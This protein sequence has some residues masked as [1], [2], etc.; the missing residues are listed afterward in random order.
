MFPAI[1]TDNIL[2]KDG[3]ASEKSNVSV[4][5][6][7]M[8][9]SYYVAIWLG[10]GL[11]LI[12]VLLWNQQ[13]NK[14]PPINQQLKR[15]AKLDYR[16]SR[17][18]EHKEMI[19][20]SM[21]NLNAWIFRMDNDIRKKRSEISGLQNSMNVELKRELSTHI[22]QKQLQDIRG[23]GQLTRDMILSQCFNGDIRSLLN[24]HR[25][26]GVGVKTQ[27]SISDW[28][29][30]TERKIPI[31][32]KGEFPGKSKIIG[33]YDYQIERRKKQYASLEKSLRSVRPLQ[34]KGLTHL[35]DLSG[36]TESSFIQSYMAPEPSDLIVRYISGIFPEWEEPPNWYRALVETYG[37]YHAE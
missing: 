31:L 4:E 29:Y 1:M 3:I 2:I 33:K 19:E 10:V 28:V 5:D 9:S 36:V 8:G 26:K 11:L 27:S 37:G 21:R 17:G 24:A 16:S 22:V 35:N 14:H 23:V 12:F 15:K 30:S 34:N 20:R 6:F 32:L 18:T 7:Q 13:F 25:V